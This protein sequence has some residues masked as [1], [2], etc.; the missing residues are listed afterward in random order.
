MRGGPTHGWGVGNEDVK[1]KKKKQL[2]DELQI[3]VFFFF[4]FFVSPLFEEGR[5]PTDFFPIMM[6]FCK[7]I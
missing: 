1:K 6:K 7:I 5:R 2:M 4:L 3:H